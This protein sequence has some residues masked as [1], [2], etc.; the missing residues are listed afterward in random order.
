[1][2][3]VV[4][5]AAGRDLDELWVYLAAEA[6]E[7]TADRVLDSVAARCELLASVPPRRPS[8]S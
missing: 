6:N 2:I 7:V 4:S 8:A 3:L 5:P 1:M